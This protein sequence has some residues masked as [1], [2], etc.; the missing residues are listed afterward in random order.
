MKRIV[1]NFNF[2]QQYFRPRY[3]ATPYH[4]THLPKRTVRDLSSKLKL[5]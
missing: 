1:H 2:Q 5:N 3:L 4:A